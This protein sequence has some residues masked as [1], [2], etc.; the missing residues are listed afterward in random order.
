VSLPKPLQERTDDFQLTD[1]YTRNP[2]R[3]GKRNYVSIFGDGS[4]SR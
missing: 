1:Y 4:F 3:E 2:C